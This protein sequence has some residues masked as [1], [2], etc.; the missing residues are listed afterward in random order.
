MASPDVEKRGIVTFVTN[1]IDPSYVVIISH[2]V[3]AFMC[4]STVSLSDNSSA[5][6]N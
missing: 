3:L 1:K 2:C 4:S 5:R 6:I